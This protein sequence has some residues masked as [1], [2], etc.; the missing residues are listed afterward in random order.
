MQS[1]VTRSSAS[2]S[3]APVGARDVGVRL[4]G[5]AVDGWVLLAL[6]LHTVVLVAALMWGGWLA[7]PVIGVAMVWGS[8]TVSHIHLHTPLFASRRANQALSGY[9]TVVLG[10]PQ[11][12]W[13]A[14]HLR[15]HARHAG[16]VPRARAAQVGCEL[17]AIGFVMVGS[18]AAGVLLP[19]LAGTALG[20]GLCA[21]QGRMEHLAGVHEG[22]STYGRWHNRLWFNDGHHAEHH[23]YPGVHWSELPARRLAA[24]RTS[25]STPFGRLFEVRPVLLGWLERLVLRVGFLR[26]RVLRAHL[27]AT[28]EVLRGLEVRH[29]LVVGGGLYPRTALVLR[30]LRPDARI[31]ILDAEAAHLEVARRYLSAREEAAIEL[32]H[33][34]WSVGSEAPGIDLVT[35]PLALRGER[36]ARDEHSAR[37][38]HAWLWERP[39]GARTAVVAWWLLKRV[40]LVP[41]R[42]GGAPAC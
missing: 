41:A 10:V 12:L 37:L 38:V 34:F 13:R 6:A 7:V 22:W 36:F 19:W 40:V 21:L 33:G 1:V 28:E 23:R 26:A 25:A 11:T 17:G 14:R 31:A 5:R 18:A 2:P 16:R 8:N 39:R 35:L 29:A 9:L 32:R 20:Y 30:A 4:L 3:P 27:R 42:T 15:H 24:A